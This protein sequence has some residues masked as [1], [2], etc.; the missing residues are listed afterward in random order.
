V[1][2]TATSLGERNIEATYPID[3]SGE[4]KE[5]VASNWREFLDQKL[6]GR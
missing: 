4:L 2:I 5:K 6:D 3:A 1:E